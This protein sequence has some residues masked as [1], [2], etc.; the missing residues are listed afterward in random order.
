M[1]VAAE[2]SF[3]GL[4]AAVL[5]A[6]P[7]PVVLIAPDGRFAAAN[8]AG[9]SFFQNSTAV[10]ARYKFSH[11]VPFGCPLISLI[12][13]VRESD[14]AVTEYRVDISSPRLGPERIVDI[15]ASPVAE[16]PG[17]VALMLLPRSVTE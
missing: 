11:F 16:R 8:Q 5:N 4:A 12:E 6:L 7:H 17:H 1:T 9:E 3:N 13:Q 15:Y 14:A 10:L 2:P